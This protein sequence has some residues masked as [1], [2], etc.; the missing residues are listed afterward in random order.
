MVQNHIDLEDI[1]KQEIEENKKRILQQSLKECMFQDEN[2]KRIV[3]NK[4]KEILCQRFCINEHN[5]NELIC[6][7]NKRG[8]K[9]EFKFNILMY[10]YK[11]KHGKDALTF[12]IT[13]YALDKLKHK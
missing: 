5:I 6:F 13:K 11:I 4:I 7:D 9:V 12:L 3:K 2:A 8:L 1:K 10:K